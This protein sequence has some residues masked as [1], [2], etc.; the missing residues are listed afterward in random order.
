MRATVS[1]LFLLLAATSAHG[2]EASLQLRDGPGKDKVQ[3]NCMT[4]HSVDYI[5]INSVFLERKGWEASVNKM[6]KVMGAPIK[7]EDVGPLVDYLTRYYGK[8]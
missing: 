7:E 5:Q 3:A 4:C 1:W 2:G 6:I 8:Q